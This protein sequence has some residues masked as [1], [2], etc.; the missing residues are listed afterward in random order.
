MKYILPFLF[1]FPLIMFS[2][3]SEANMY[4]GTYTKKEGH[5]DGQAKGIYLVAQN[6]VTGSLEM[7]KTV[8]EI[9]NP[10]FVKSGKRGKFLFAVSELGPADGDTG[11]FYSFGIEENGDLKQLSKLPTGGIAP[12]HIALDRS[13]KYAFVSNYMGGVVMVYKI[14]ENGELKKWQELKMKNPDKSHT[15]SVKISK[16]N[17]HAYI[18]DLGNDKIWTYEF[19]A[20]TGCLTAL[21][22]LAA[23]LPEGSGPRHMAFSKNG[24]FL[25]SMNELNSTVSAFSINKDGGLENI[26]H[27]TT[28]PK[29]FTGNNSGADIHIHPSGAFLYASNRGHNSIAVYKIDETTGKLEIVEQATIAGKTP[30]NFALSPYG[31]F[32][33]AASQD[34]GN[35]TIFNVDEKTGK[36]KMQTPIFEIKT[37][38]CL[39]FKNLDYQS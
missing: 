3:N 32:L 18:A 8:A 39:E 9:T 11:Y 23:A 29:N 19:D 28:L 5:V 31:K 26:Q 13:G 22:E 6:P 12:C 34:S 7:K 25:Y 36:L 4:V 24:S 33:Y 16:D 20:A 14:L 37:P 10:S 21:P 1:L 27:I 38:V 30:R 35:I 17:R 2:Q 15:H